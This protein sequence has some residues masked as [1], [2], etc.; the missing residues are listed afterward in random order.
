M[1]NINRATVSV[2][3]IGGRC[4]ASQA[5]RA[6]YLDV[7]YGRGWS[8]NWVD[9]PLPAVAANYEFGR[10]IALDLRVHLKRLPAWP[11][12][13]PMP[14][15]LHD[16]AKEWALA[17][18]EAN[19]PPTYV[20]PEALTILRPRHLVE[21]DLRNELIARNLSSLAPNSAHETY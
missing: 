13:K 9:H 19:L 15:A 2:T 5:T 6:G 8:S 20:F 12:G 3:Q 14:A 21:A 17:D 10:H 7:K 11:A 1:T 4:E 16:A 18:K